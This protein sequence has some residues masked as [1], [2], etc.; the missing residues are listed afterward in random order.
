[1]YELFFAKEIDDLV[2][3]TL[4]YAPCGY[5]KVYVAMLN[6][7][8]LP[9]IFQKKLG[10]LS[11]FSLFAITVTIISCIIIFG[12]SLK[13]YNMPEE[14]VAMNYGLKITPKDKELIYWN[15]PML[16]SYLAGMLNIFEGN[17][18]ILNFYAET[19]KP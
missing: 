19:S 18:Q 7:L 15:T 1:V 14:N 9:I 2:C 5:G 4:Q 11:K 17:Q 6:I 16:P 12:I 8:L 10:A 3:E 13:I